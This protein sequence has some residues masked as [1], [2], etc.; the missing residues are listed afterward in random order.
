MPGG[1][2]SDGRGVDG[3]GSVEGGFC[4]YEEELCFVT[5]EFE[6]V[7]GQPCFYRRDAGFDVGEGGAKR[8]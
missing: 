2:L 7:V 6:E 5:A 4:A 1:G 8:K 3:S